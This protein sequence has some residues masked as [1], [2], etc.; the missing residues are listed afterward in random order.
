MRRARSVLAAIVPLT[1]AIA[2]SVAALRAADCNENGVPDER[3]VREER[4]VLLAPVASPAPATAHEPVLADLDRDGK[5]E[6]VL[7]DST[8]GALAV[9]RPGAAGAFEPPR[10]VPAGGPPQS[11]AALDLDGDGD[12]DLAAGLAQLGQVVTLLQG[13]GGA[14]APGPAADLAGHIASALAAADL[15]LD[16]DL[17]LFA[18]AFEACCPGN[19][20]L[21]IA[22]RNDG[23]SK[24][25]AG[26]LL[27]SS[28]RSPPLKIAA[29]DLD[30]DQD[31]DLV[32]TF[33]DGTGLVAY[34]YDGDR[35]RPVASVPGLTRFA[36]GDFDGDGDP[37]IAAAGP[38][39]PGKVALLWN[40]V[41]AGN[42]FREERQ[43]L[44]AAVASLA[45]ADLDSDGRP[46]LAGT[47][48]AGRGCDAPAGDAWLALSLGGGR[49]GW[50]VSMRADRPLVQA[51][52]G[53]L[54]SDGKLDLVSLG[55]PTAL[56]VFRGALATTSRDCDSS[57]VPDECELEANDCDSNGIPDACDAALADC[58]G[59]GVPDSCDPDCDQ[60]GRPDACEIAGGT[61]ADCDRNGILDV[62]ELLARDA[63]AN[64]VP[65]DCDVSASPSADC[66]SNGIPDEEDLRPAA[67]LDGLP[68]LPWL[69]P[70]TAAVTFWGGIWSLAPADLDGNGS[71]DLVVALGDACC[72]PRLAAVYAYRSSGGSLSAPH[73]ASRFEAPLHVLPV[74]ADRDGIPD[75]V[76][77]RWPGPCGDRGGAFLLEGRRPGAFSRPRRLDAGSTPYFALAADLDGDGD[78]DLACLD[79]NADAGGGQPALRTLAAD[80]QGAFAPWKALPL[81]GHAAVAVASDVDRDG[82]LDL[83][84][85]D[86][87]GLKVSLNAGKGDLAPPQGVAPTQSGR[88]LVGAGDLDGDGGDELAV[89][90]CGQSGCEVTVWKHSTAS[91][92]TRL[93][94]TAAGVYPQG[95]VLDDVDADGDV[96]A[97]VLGVVFPFLSGSNGAAIAILRNPGDA[98]L[99]PLLPRTLGGTGV[100]A[101][102]LL[103][104]DGDALSELALA[105]TYDPYI[106]VH[107]NLGGGDFAALALRFVESGGASVAAAGDLDSDG[108]LDLALAG[109]FSGELGVLRG[110][111]D[112]GL[113]DR[114]VAWATSNLL[115]VLSADLDGDADADLAA[116]DGSGIQV[117][118]QDAQALLRPAPFVQTDG[119]ALGLAVG[120]LDADGDADLAAAT[121]LLVDT[122]L[123]VSPGAFAVT[124]A[125]P[126]AGNPVSIVAAD[127]DSDGDLDLATANANPLLADNVTIFVNPGDGKL[128]PRRNLAVPLFSTSIAAGDLEADGD[129]DLLVT[130]LDPQ[131]LANATLLRNPGQ[132]DLAAAPVPE[133]PPWALYHA[134]IED[135]GGDG[136]AELALMGSRGVTLL[137]ARAGGA[138]QRILE[139]PLYVPAGHLLTADMDRDGDRD[140]VGTVEDGW[141]TTVL[142]VRNDGGALS[143][144]HDATGVPDECE[145]GAPPRFLRGDAD[146]DGTWNI[147]DP[148]ALLE[149]LFL[150]SRRLPCRDA[151]DADDDGLLRLT[152]AVVLLSYL[153]LGGRQ[154]PAPF[155]RC[156]YDPTRDGVEC[157]EFD[158]CGA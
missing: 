68:P 31:L 125:Q 141:L 7:P 92:F 132:G 140:L 3:D 59:N 69:P 50:T 113:G 57:G 38:I 74:D 94:Q 115:F 136:L 123:Q 88:D 96:D 134:V 85:S 67:R 97:A 83:A 14:F 60:N 63:S 89:A 101:A 53:D 127:I 147:T 78:E 144:D 40:D 47:N 55:P 152:D 86:Q 62:C 124:D 100:P 149:H 58:D 25:E 151:A 121:P 119:P 32:L 73:L 154:L 133:A 65:D 79:A 8:A 116:S 138:F 139:C 93:G 5:P 64:G 16:G 84:L 102:A 27:R 24:L 135:L 17:D 35:H 99:A 142:F 18:G 12:L 98:R 54:D 6:V 4:P 107:R 71:P 76:A 52:L 91:V 137:E 114:R 42:G 66:N 156:G 126:A 28:G 146:A 45:S 13:A 19:Q 34:R 120:D 112:G 109:K 29:G 82:D 131:A 23:G 150:N 10:N 9:F 61:G 81:E 87:G 72:P 145:P 108:R 2:L 37:D 44:P 15:D 33:G 11:V 106:S 95:L 56:I 157:V 130:N 46:D 77:S 105:R 22:L 36:S 48:Q 155:P 129:A 75:L 110:T 143:F 104:L 118:L 1:A 128:R 21:V 39:E 51:A 41:A 20:A 111:G 70:A 26:I 122:V 158:P 49:L 43:P 90:G 117:L 80:G 153:F 148:V 30:G 103:D